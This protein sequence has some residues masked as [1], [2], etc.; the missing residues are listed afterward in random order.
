MAFG[1]TRIRWDEWGR[2]EAMVNHAMQRYPISAICAYDTR[3]TPAEMLASG[4]ATHPYLAHGGEHR[5]NPYYVEPAGVLI[6][7]KLPEAGTGAFEKLGQFRE[8][9]GRIAFGG[10]RLADGQAHFALAVR[11]S[12]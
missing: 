6:D 4:P 5:S 9:R 12:G 10:R 7:P 1:S 3:S 11:Q 2:Y 8:H